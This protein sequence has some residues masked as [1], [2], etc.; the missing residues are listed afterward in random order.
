MPNTQQVMRGNLGADPKYFPPKTR[1]DGS[2]QKAYL[3]AMVYRNRRIQQPDGS[4]ADSPAGP[5]RVT[6]KFFGQNAELLN[7]AAFKKG[8]AVVATGTLGEPDA[9]ISQKD[10]MAHART[11]IIGDTLSSDEIR[12]QQKARFEA[13]KS[14]QQTADHSEG[15]SV[16]QSSEMAAGPDPWDVDGMGNMPQQDQAAGRTR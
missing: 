13:Q 16:A 5:E 4:W 14:Q 12:Y 7:A 1:G 9:Y 3:E 8:D 10:N 2:V 6:V 11:V 15:A